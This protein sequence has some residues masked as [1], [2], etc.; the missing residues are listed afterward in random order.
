MKAYTLRLDND[1]AKVLRHLAVEEGRSI[2]DILEELI[3]QYI[4]ARKETLEI[5]SQPGLYESVI[6]SSKAARRGK[7][8]KKLDEL[9]D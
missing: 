7:K 4:E 8:G 9:D 2:R 6:E 5:L 1:K 3:D